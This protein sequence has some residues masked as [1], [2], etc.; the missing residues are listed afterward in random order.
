MSIKE[1]IKRILDEIPELPGVYIMKD[2]FGEI[3]YVGK[4]KSLKK[5]VRQYFSKNIYDNKVRAMVSNIDDIEYILTNNEIEALILENNLIK[6]NK[7]F[8]NILLRDDKTFPYIQITDDDYPKIL[9]TRNKYDKKGSF[10]GPYTDVTL[11][12]NYIKELKE[13]FGIRDCNKNITNSIL[14]NDRPCLNYHIGICK[15]PCANKISQEE[16]NENIRI[17]KD[18]LS[19]KHKI[20]KEK[21]TQKMLEASKELRFEDAGRYK[22]LID[23]LYKMKELQ[24][25]SLNKISKEQH[26]L[27]FY[28]ANS[29][30][31]ITLF[32]YE[33]GNLIKKEN[34][35]F[36]VIGDIDDE[37]TTFIVQY[38]M[39]NNSIPS[40]LFIDFTID[41]ELV[42]EAIKE[43]TDIKISIVNAISGRN[44]EI[45][46][47]AN[48]NAIETYKI[49]DIKRSKKRDFIDE[50]KLELEKITNV[51]DINIIESF[52][53]S[54]I[55]GSDS[56]GVKVCFE[57]FKKKPSSY[58]KY[59]IKTV[60]GIDDY[61]S[62]REIIE[63]RLNKGEFPDLILLDGGKGH[64]STIKKL[65][66]DLN[67]NIKVFGIYK[68][69]NHRTKGLCDEEN[70]YYIDRK[71]KLFKFLSEVQN[72]VHRFAITFHRTKR[73][74][75]M[76]KSD[77]DNIRNIGEKRK[78]ELIKFF[79]SID[80]IKK[81]TFEELMLVESMNENAANNVLEYFRNIK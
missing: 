36:D 10:F 16:Y 28:S 53:I 6:K 33:N 24:N 49:L 58:R 45:L 31:V 21:F 70:L 80:N 50:I 67:I 23:N 42:S 12:N 56:V 63:R 8:Y 47:L 38:Y 74:N 44:K 72:E 76:L 15:A 62:M 59:N 61:R 48:R 34:F 5:R 20:I 14:N 73:N 1:Y 30:I 65:L 81:A 66:E 41:T 11:I 75:S 52:D 37:I 2:I 26:F 9:K 13:M 19:G 69:E 40:E 57:N 22:S 51:K 4:A 7:P 35:D 3:I 54:N 71:S 27:S 79:K 78:L 39:D 55:N 32:V 43:Y 46:K 25:I 18:F 17:I 68:D 64:V 77:L 29:I 60:N